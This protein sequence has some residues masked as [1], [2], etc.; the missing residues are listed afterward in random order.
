MPTTMART[1]LRSEPLEW[2]SS[3]PRSSTRSSPSSRRAPRRSAAVAVVAWAAQRAQ[4]S[5]VCGRR[6]QKSGVCGLLLHMLE[7]REGASRPLAEP[8]TSDLH[9]RPL[10]ARAAGR[11]G[12][13]RGGPSAVAARA[14]VR[15]DMNKI[16][17]R[18]DE[19]HAAAARRSGS[20]DR[21]HT[22][23]IAGSE[24]RRQSRDDETAKLA[25]K[26]SEPAL[27]GLPKTITSGVAMTSRVPSRP[28]RWIERGRNVN[29]SDR[30]GGRC[31]I[32]LGQ[33]TPLRRVL[34]LR[35]VSRAAYAPSAA[36]T[37]TYDPRRVGSSHQT[38]FRSG[39][40]KPR[41]NTPGHVRGTHRHG[42]DD[43]GLAGTRSNS[44][45]RAI[46]RVRGTL[47]WVCEPGP[48][49]HARG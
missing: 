43:G 12:E 7:E 25:Q 36:Q 34:G 13:A 26:V 30:S 47:W 39:L 5:G 3:S 22:Q 49:R 48:K 27:A 11:R 29:Q 31:C 21:R 9:D 38:I 35:Y 37:S 14:T 44:A 41:P 17:F 33:S 20:T 28:R 19:A 40:S 46:F 15:R 4:T 16:S 18:A 32:I 42:A 2:S 10:R 45:G 8:R 6:A 23:Q 1:C 24:T